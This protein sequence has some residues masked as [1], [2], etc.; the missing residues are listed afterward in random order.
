MVVVRFPCLRTALTQK[1][2]TGPALNRRSKL[3][4][5]MRALLYSQL[6]GFSK[7]FPVSHREAL[8]LGIVM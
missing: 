1:D 5:H 6:F 7:G 3:A 8:A 4:M 2:S